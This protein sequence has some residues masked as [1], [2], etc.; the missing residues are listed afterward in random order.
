MSPY[1]ARRFYVGTYLVYVIK[2]SCKVL[3]QYSSYISI[4]INANVADIILNAALCHKYQL[5]H[6]EQRWFMSDD[7]DERVHVYDSYLAKSIIR[8]CL[9]IFD[10]NHQKVNNPGQIAFSFNSMCL[11][12]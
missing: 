12:G 9:E 5:R 8:S 11:S 7:D 3:S 4:K 2:I 10:T 1:V 6:L